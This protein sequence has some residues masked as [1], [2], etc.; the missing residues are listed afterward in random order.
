MMPGKIRERTG[1]E[2]VDETQLREHCD[3][4]VDAKT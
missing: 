4:N 3:E 2:G 1:R